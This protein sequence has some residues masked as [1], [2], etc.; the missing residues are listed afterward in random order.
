MNIHRILAAVLLCSILSAC[1]YVHSDELKEVEIKSTP[2]A[3]EAVEVT[4]P[5]TSHSMTIRHMVANGTVFVECYVPNFEFEKGAADQNEGHLIISVDHKPAFPVYKA[6]FIIKDLSPGRH[7]IEVKLSD[8]KGIP[9]K[10][11]EKQFF[12]NI[13]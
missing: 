4:S 12:V 5:E 9:I 3:F 11:M 7:H 6:A 10:G 1:Q 2:Q 13:K 8:H